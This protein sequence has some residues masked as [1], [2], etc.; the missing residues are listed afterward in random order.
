MF[1]AVL[2]QEPGRVVL[3]GVLPESFLAILSVHE[4]TV[5]SRTT[6]ETS[7]SGRERE[8]LPVSSKEGAL[9]GL[10]PIEGVF[11]FPR[12]PADSAQRLQSSERLFQAPWLSSD[13]PG[14]R[15]R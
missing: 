7:V 13:D 5:A 11:G 12:W 2:A 8:A 4:L 3:F 14:T 9:S 15:E 1:G 6:L 10:C